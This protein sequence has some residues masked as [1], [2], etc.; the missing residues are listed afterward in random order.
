MK[1]A[2][3]MSKNPDSGNGS[4]NNNN[5]NRTYG[6]SYQ[7]GV[8]GVGVGGMMGGYQPPVHYAASQTKVLEDSTKA[9]YQADETASNV[10]QKMTEQRQQIGGANNNV[11]AMRK[12]TEQAKQE[13][14]E[15]NKKY[16]LKKQ[17]LYI[18]IAML[19]M[20]DFLLFVRLLQCHGSFFC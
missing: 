7:Q 3:N 16:R 2:T 15:L 12:A 1:R 4:N 13:L 17:R 19:G 9:Y 6:T 18:T 20:A 11:W 5:S 14:I 8:G 10:L